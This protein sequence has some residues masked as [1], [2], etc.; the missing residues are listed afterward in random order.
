MFGQNKIVHREIKHFEKWGIFTNSKTSLFLLSKNK[1]FSQ[2]SIILNNIF[3]FKL[4][5]KQLRV[6]EPIK[7]IS[8][9]DFE[10]FLQKKIGK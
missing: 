2:N 9:K 7:D 5:I 10:H 1:F 3:V 4:P 6:K 8:Y